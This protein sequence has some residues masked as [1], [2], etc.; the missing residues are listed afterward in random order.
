[1][2]A[3][4]HI[5]IPARMASERLPGKP[6]HDIAGKPMIAHV[7]GHA[8]QSDAERINQARPESTS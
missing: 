8:M 2:S 1:M 5:V 6:L 4:Y 3:E 7:I